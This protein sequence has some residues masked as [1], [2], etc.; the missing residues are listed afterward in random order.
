[1]TPVVLIGGGG[2]AKVVA[3][4]VGKIKHYHI[5]GYTAP[6]AG[7]APLN[8]AYLGTDE[9][10]PDLLT[11]KRV[12]GAVIGIGI[13]EINGKRA[14]LH[15]SVVG[16]GL[17]LPAIVSPTAVVNEPVAIG[18]GTVVM[19]GV[20]I[21]PGTTIGELCILN[22]NATVEHDCTVGSYSH[23]APGAVLCG[24][25]TVGDETMIGTSACVL[26]GLYI[27]SRCL[28]GAGATVTRDLTEP[29]VYL[30]NP[31]RR[32]RT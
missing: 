14:A 27:A 21:N 12:T 8:L 19:D 20:V 5:V 6:I 31:A 1:M 9:I 4:V 2:H 25:V 13:V 22:T 29:G 7:S 23:I 26:P 28:I 30:G 10:L 16:H 11:S 24:G 17:S 18:N 32:I 15:R 3:A